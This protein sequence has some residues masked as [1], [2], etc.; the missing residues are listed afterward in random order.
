MEAD[1]LLFIIHQ[2]DDKENPNAFWSSWY[3][4]TQVFA[5][6]RHNPFEVFL[7][8]SSRKFFSKFKLCLRNISK[9]ELS[10]LI[11]DIEEKMKQEGRRNRVYASMFTNIEQ[12]EATP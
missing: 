2:I 5:E 3:P 12:I 11:K 4:A 9:E 1:F 7:K 8:S 10:E 6:H